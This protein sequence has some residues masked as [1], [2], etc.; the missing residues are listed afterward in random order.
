MSSEMPE[1]LGMSDRILVMHEGHLSGEFPIE[2]ATQEALMAAAVGK[3]YGVK[4]E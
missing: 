1:V 4:Q 2:Q 3:Q